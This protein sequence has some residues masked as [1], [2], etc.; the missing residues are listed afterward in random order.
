MSAVTPISMDRLAAGDAAEIER[1]M[2]PIEAHRDAA[3]AVFFEKLEA[4]NAIIAERAGETR[5]RDAMKDLRQALDNALNIQSQASG[6]RWRLEHPSGPPPAPRVRETIDATRVRYDHAVGPIRK[7]AGDETPFGAAELA[8]MPFTLAALGIGEDVDA[9]E[10]IR[11]ALSRLQ[12][13]VNIPDYDGRRL[14]EEGKDREGRLT[15]A[16]RRKLMPWPPLAQHATDEARGWHEELKAATLAELGDDASE[17]GQVHARGRAWLTFVEHFPKSGR[18]RQ[19]VVR[20]LHQAGLNV[21]WG[22]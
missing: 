16:F 13:V 19:Q 18:P 6:Q 10:R 9:E 15:F 14:V 22:Q 17:V 20:E 21:E 7:E 4:L 12:R 11:L 3:E 8:N 5:A 1:A 2:A